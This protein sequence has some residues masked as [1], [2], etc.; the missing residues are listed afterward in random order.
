MA[1]TFSKRRNISANC[2]SFRGADHS[3]S[4]DV[5]DNHD[6]ACVVEGDEFTAVCTFDGCGDASHAK[7]GSVL[8]SLLVK[9]SLTS[10]MP[11]LLQVMRTRHQNTGGAWLAK[12][13]ADVISRDVL[14]GL[15]AHAV[16]AVGSEPAA[17][18]EFV[19]GHLL[20][21]MF[22]AVIVEEFVIVMGLGDGAFE[23]NGELT[24]VSATQSNTPSYLGYALLPESTRMCAL[25]IFA[26]QERSAVSSVGV[27]S[28]GLLYLLAAQGWQTPAG[29][30][31]VP[32]WSEL[33][34][35]SSPPGTM[36]R[37]R[38]CT[39]DH[40]VPVVEES[41]SG[42]RVGAAVRSAYLRDDIS[43]ARAFLAQHGP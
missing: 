23:L 40:C 17:I 22:L 14:D 20:C 29:N 38:D 24:I 13:M 26:I 31:R 25:Q 16:T 15:H 37:L 32:H 33:G 43:G 41:E 6:V 27:Y 34:V 36:A 30:G 2:W 21:T 19:S 1:E 5:Q 8:S 9:R 10:R 35:S 7:V 12:Q 28:D 11:T 3:K 42:L 4:F 18:D 39:F